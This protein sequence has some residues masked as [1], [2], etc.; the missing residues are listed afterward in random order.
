MEVL[1]F[2]FVMSMFGN[3]LRGVNVSTVARLTHYENSFI[4]FNSRR[5]GEIGIRTR[6][7]IWR[8]QSHVGSTPTL[9]ILLFSAIS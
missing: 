8:E 4:I 1:L 5:G 7:K 9:G 3:Y 2:I 6:L